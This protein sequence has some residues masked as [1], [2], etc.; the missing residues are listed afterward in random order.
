MQKSRQKA[1][2]RQAFTREYKL[3]AVRLSREGTKSVATVADEL[4][5]ASN[6]LHKWRRDFER[7]G[8]A[9]FPGNGKLNSHDEELHVLR[10]ELKRVTEERDFLKKTAVSSTCQRNEPNSC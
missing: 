4:G 2:K 3:E 1:G 8:L 10:R 5:I 9:A 6:Q 7:E